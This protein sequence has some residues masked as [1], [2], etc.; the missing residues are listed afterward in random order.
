MIAGIRAGS[1]ESRNLEP[2]YQQFER[3][4]YYDLPVG[5][6]DEQRRQLTAA[7][8][9]RRLFYLSLPNGLQI[10]GQACYRGGDANGKS[11]SSFAHIIFHEA[12]EDQKPWSVLD[13]L[14]LWGASGWLH[15]DAAEGVRSRRRSDRWPRCSGGSRRRSAAMPSSVS[16][17]RRRTGRSK[18]PAMSSLRHGG[19]W[20]PIAA[21]TGSWTY[22]R[23]S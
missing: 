2:F 19:A 10:L 22:S 14:K 15:D 6:T 23:P 4:V 3:H 5:T 12:K 11:E 17:A 16:S 7:T 1:I 13:A 8:A 21:A 18:I 20:T 9:P